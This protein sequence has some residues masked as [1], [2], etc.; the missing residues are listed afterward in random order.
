MRTVQNIVIAVRALRANIMRSLL[1]VLGIVIGVGAVI[2]MVAVGEG[3]HHRVAEQIRTL[4]TNLLMVQPGSGDATDNRPTL[5]E[6]DAEAI[7][8]EIASVTAASPAVRDT[9][10]F[11]H[12]NRRWQA[13]LTGTEPDYFLARDWPIAAGRAFDHAESGRAAKVAV[14]GAT[15]AEGLFSDTDP[16]GEVIRVYDVPL[17]VIGVLLPKGVS[18]TGRD[19]DDAIFVP[20][21]TA[22]LRL[23]GGPH[24]IVRD[25]VEY[26]LVKVA[27]QDGVEAATVEIAALLRQRHRL[28]DGTP[29]DFR[30]NDPAATMLA[31]RGATRTLAFLLMAI[32]SVSLLVGGISIMNIMLVSITERKR[33]IGLRLA[34]GARRSD[35]LKQF[36]IE[37]ITLCILGGVFG[38]I[39]GVGAAALI[40]RLAGWPIFIGPE[41]IVLSVGFASCV[42]MLFGLYP[43]VKASRLNPIDA[44]R[45]D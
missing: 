18:G 25:A 44:L 12:G 9:V 31:Q 41:A 30:L 36:V 38:V 43:A 2:T 27:S 19:Q 40:A 11:V 29:D 22:K 24:E 7:R 45:F 1:T 28:P 33:E 26:I 3:A 32:A 21:S 34:V 10:V 5:T 17:T 42:G 20:I 15:I 16:I 35:I 6:A 23:I 13:L 8:R 14:I 37:A 4:G 39:G